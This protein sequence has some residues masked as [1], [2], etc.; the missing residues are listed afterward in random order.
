MLD[1]FKFPSS[2]SKE[3]FYRKYAQGPNDTWPELARRLVEDVCGTRNGTTHALMSKTEMDELRQ[4]IVDMKFIPGGRYLYYA[5]RPLSFYNNCACLKAEEDTREEWGALAERAC[6]WLMSGAG[7][8]IDYSIIRPSGRSLRRTGGIASGPIPLMNIINEVGRNVMQGGSR[9]SAIW[10]GLDSE[11]DDIMDFIHMKNWSSEIVSMKGKDFNF[12]A[13][14]DM[15]NISVIFSKDVIPNKESFE[16]SP[17]FQETVKQMCMTGEPGLSF[18][19]G[20][21]RYETLRNAC[22]EVTSSYD[23]DVCN[24]GSINFARVESVEELRDVAYL[25]AKFLICGSVRAVLPYKKAYDIREAHRKIG[26]GLMGYHEWCIKNNLQY[27]FNEDSQKWLNA[28]NDSTEEGA[29]EICDRFF[30]SPCEKF[31]AVA[32]AGTISIL[33]GTTSGIEPVFALAYKRRYLVDGN[34]WKYQ[35][36]IDNIAQTLLDKYGL[37]STN[38]ETAYSL[39]KNIARRL[40]VLSSIQTHVDMGISSTINMPEWGS[41]YNNESTWQSVAGLIAH[42][43]PYLRGVTIYPHN[44]RQGQILTEVSYEEASKNK[45]VIFDECEETCHGGICGI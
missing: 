35:Y 7:I 10:A 15:T 14:M 44:A 26:L 5:G 45:G 28:F 12:P 20:R 16:Y 24:L 6:N 22:A 3:I 36:V 18:N 43:A 2:F 9:R 8:G 13:A 34:K 37:D 25:A 23:S 38:L 4:F 42:Y 33:A 1:K 39:S 19:W 31:H 30:L 27:T 32:P 40:K 17:V 41:A 29:N 21:N 11:H